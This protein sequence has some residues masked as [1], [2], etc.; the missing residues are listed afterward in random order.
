M[1][2]LHCSQ[3]GRQEVLFMCL[4]IKQSLKE[5]TPRQ[6]TTLYLN[7]SPYVFCND[8]MQHLEIREFQAYV[9]H[10]ALVTLKEVQNNDEDVDDYYQRSNN[11]LQMLGK[12]SI[13]CSKCFYDVYE[14]R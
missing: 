11:V 12:P 1:G 7:F 14:K 6:S 4:H 10:I 9:E 5:K 8:C 13:H 3:H 2:V